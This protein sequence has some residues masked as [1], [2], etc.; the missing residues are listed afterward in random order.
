[1]A[2]LFEHRFASNPAQHAFS[3]RPVETDA[4]TGELS[5]SSVRASVCF[6]MDFPTFLVGSPQLASPVLLLQFC[7]TSGT[8]LVEDGRIGLHKELQ[9]VEGESVDL[10]RFWEGFV[11]FAKVIFCG[12]C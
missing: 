6:P 11:K 9:H 1:M 4:T 5:F 2:G 12:H 8:A 3:N 10:E 7:P